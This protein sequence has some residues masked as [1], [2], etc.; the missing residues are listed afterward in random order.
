VRIHITGASGS[1]CSTL[2][3]ALAERLGCAYLDG[4]NY[5]WLKPEPPFTDKRAADE[6]LGLLKRDM[7]AAKDFVLAGSIV[8]WGEEVEGVFDLIVF[9]YLDAKVRVERLRRRELERFGTADE[10]FLIWATQYDE[11]TR[12]GRS[13]PKHRAWLSTRSCAILEVSGN[14]SVEER[15][16]I[17]L[18]EL[19]SS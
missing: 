7:A 1:G 18:Q 13:L 12:E 2:G 8:G 4:D 10:D 5:Y 17:V 9:L 19:R 11:G 15:L 6:R 3:A 14:L 16:K